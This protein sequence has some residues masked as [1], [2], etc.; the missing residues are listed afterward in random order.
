MTGTEEYLHEQASE[1]SIDTPNGEWVNVSS[2]VHTVSDGA[3]Y[4]DELAWRG[5]TSASTNSDPHQ[6]RLR[7][8][9]VD[10]ETD[11]QVAEATAEGP[12]VEA[13][14]YGYREAA[15]TLGGYVYGG[16]EVHVHVDVKMINN[17]S[18]SVSV[19]N[20]GGKAYGRRAL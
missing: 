8:E 7:V 1:A 20:W 18:S 13:F 6:A 19:R 9:V 16:M 17:A 3:V 15:A 14:D 2:T 5:E 11:A 12:K 10:P 4:I